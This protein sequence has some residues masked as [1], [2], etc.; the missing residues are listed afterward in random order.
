MT[1]ILTGRITEWNPARGYGFVEAGNQRVFLHIH[2]FAERHKAPEVGDLIEFALGPDR[3]GRTCAQHAIHV[4][5]GGRIRPRDILLLVALMISPA[6]ALQRLSVH[7]DLR[8]LFAYWALVSLATFALY[9]W[10]KFQA[11][12]H[13]WRRPENTLHLFALA[14]GWPGAFLAQRWLRHKCSKPAFLAV[15]WLIVAAHLYVATDYQLAW[16]LARGTQRLYQNVRT[17]WK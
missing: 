6:L 3:R 2:D 12:N 4:R 5:D 13:A 10:D 7:F 11:R 9:A 17:G 14:G 16:R 15:F 1:P 8:L